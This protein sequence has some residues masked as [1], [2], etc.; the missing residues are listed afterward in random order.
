M[1]ADTEYKIIHTVNFTEFQDTRVHWK[2]FLPTL[3]SN[4]SLV[5]NANIF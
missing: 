3:F 2:N 4:G 5:A 1:S